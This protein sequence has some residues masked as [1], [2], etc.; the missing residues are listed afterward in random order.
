MPCA[1]SDAERLWIFDAATGFEEISGN[2]YYDW[3][4]GTTPVCPSNATIEQGSKDVPLPT[5][6]GS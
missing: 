5:T 1:A 4:N 3:V 2:M 6:Q